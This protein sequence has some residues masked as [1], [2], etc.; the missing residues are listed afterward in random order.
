MASA[1]V[2]GA[3]FMKA[4]LPLRAVAIASNIA[5]IVYAVFVSNTAILILHAALLPLNT[6]R[7]VQHL[8][9]RRTIRHALE[10]EP[11][12]EK[13]L[14]LMEQKTW[15]AGATIFVRGDIAETIYVL[16]EGQIRLTEL[17]VTIGPI[18][19]FGE[20]GPFLRDKTRLA[21][22]VCQTDCTVYTLSESRMK[23]LVLKEP[24]F[25]LYL[26]KLIAERMHDNMCNIH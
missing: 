10:Q 1:L 7:I 17:E 4:I 13:L 2:F 11:N 3:F 25:G 9:L 18:T 22:A 23:E 8:K 24:A 15:N 21:T 20:I 19:I 26:T 5:F 14:P 16:T 6:L 12:I